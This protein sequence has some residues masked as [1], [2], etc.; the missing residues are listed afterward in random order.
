VKPSA[1]GPSR[2]LSGR[3]SHPPQQ[4]RSS[5]AFSGLS[6]I[7]ATESLNDVKQCYGDHGFQAFGLI[8]SST[9]NPRSFAICRSNT[10]DMS[11][12]NEMVPWYIGHPGDETA[13]VSLA[14]ELLKI[15]AP[16]VMQ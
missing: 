8:S 12:L 3:R 13:Y 7:L 4:N 10:G 5:S 11:R 6:F 15:Q 14:V 2:K 1:S 9:V 16:Q